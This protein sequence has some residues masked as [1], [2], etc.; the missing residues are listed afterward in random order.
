MIP[1]ALRACTY[2]NQQ[3]SVAKERINEEVYIILICSKF[4]KLASYFTLYELFSLHITI[5]DQRG[6]SN[7]VLLGTLKALEP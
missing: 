6:A 1:H 5:S 7:F 4:L 3:A 2:E